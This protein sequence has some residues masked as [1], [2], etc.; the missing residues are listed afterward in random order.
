MSDLEQ[1]EILDLLKKNNIDAH[2][3]PSH[4]GPTLKCYFKYRLN[5]VSDYK[6]LI[7]RL[8]NIRDLGTEGL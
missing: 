2:I 5:N 7:Q 6:G 8:I 3:E 4:K 1:F